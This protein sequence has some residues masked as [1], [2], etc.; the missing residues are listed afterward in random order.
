MIN[1]LF[2]F[3][4]ALFMV[5]RGA[6]IATKY[7]AL[8]AES[9]R[10]SKYTVG[11]III[12]AISILPEMFISINAAIS[13]IP[14]FGLGM[15]FGSN[16]ADLTLI[17]A[18]IIF[19]AGRGLKVESKILK[20]HAVYP[21]ILLLPIV[22]GFDGHFSRLEGVALIIT[23]GIFYYLALKN[24]IDGA[25][26]VNNGNGRVKSSAMLLLSMA[27]L[28]TG[29]HFTVTSAT[30]LAGYFG[31]SPILIGMLIVGLGTTMPEFFFSL[32]SVKRE[33]D[34]LAVGDILGTVLADATIVVGILALVSP[35]Y[36][37]TKIIY[38][39]GLFMVA[40]SFMLFHFM[41][42][43]RTLTKREAWM[44]LA[45]WIVFVFVE[46]IANTN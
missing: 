6:I 41:R 24:G 27:I 35:F 9:Y 20:N 5:I 8:L 19:L 37:P 12:A 1:N 32:K 34:S 42:S 44:L 22:L 2:I 39:T 45:F 31:V 15:L 3:I 17:F 38:I 23:G 25:I 33:D 4:V 36:F 43:G 28:L 7:A 16:I 21:L 46:F 14:S 13:G 10:L 30:S 18:L 29:A 11:F 40:A 26:P